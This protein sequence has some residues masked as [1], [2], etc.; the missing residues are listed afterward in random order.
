MNYRL[1]TQLVLP[2]VA[3]AALSALLH[4]RW[5]ADGFF[6]N[7]AAGFVGSLVTVGYVDWILRRHETERWEEADSRIQAR[8]SKLAFTTITGIRTSFGYG[9][10]VFDRVAMMTGSPEVMRN[11]VLRV[12]IHVLLPTAEARVAALNQEQGK[13]FAA[14][15][16][17]ASVDCGVLLDRFG[18]R[19]EPKK[20]AAVLDL[21]GHLDSAQTY[22]RVFPDVAGVPVA[23]LPK[24]NTSAE[25]MQ[26]SE[27]ALSSMPYQPP[28]QSSRQ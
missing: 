24:M 20:I 2:L 13:S 7:L 11:E 23:Q 21:Q 28:M 17:R 15:L 18:H 5:P 19:L 8:L 3:A 14:H 9:T 27:L 22:W 10:E 1:V 6:L 4:L 25:D 26:T 12:A 16:Q